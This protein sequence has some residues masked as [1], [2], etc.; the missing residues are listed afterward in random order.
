MFLYILYKNYI[1]FIN[2]KL[3]K[4]FLYFCKKKIEKTF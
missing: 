3:D 1:I 4:R 2:Y